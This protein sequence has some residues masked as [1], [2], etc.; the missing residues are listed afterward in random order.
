M[1]RII[2]LTALFGAFSILALGQDAK[3]AKPK[4][5]GTETATTTSSAA[6]LAKA[7]LAAHGG[8][9]LRSIKSLVLRGSVDITASASAQAIPATFAMIFSGEKY[10]LDLMNPFQPI[11]QVFDG[12]NTQTTVQN[13]F[14]LPPINRIGFIMLSKVG[15]PN[16]PVASLPAANKKK[17]GFRITSPE[18]FYTDYLVDE[19]TGQVKG[20]ESSYEVNGR[21]VTTSVAI[22][23]CRLVEGVLVPEKFS[24]RFDLG[25]LTAYADFKA[26]DI[27]V[28]TEIAN[29]VF[30]IQK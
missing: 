15:D 9:K 11:S 10:R 17:N 18:G 7:A 29:D 30:T 6:E 25:Q 8:E 13:G 19:K 28:N 4:E 5:E 26:K 1:R 3:T 22:D 14:E 27:Q 20:Y 23:K 16:F 24:Q 12:V 2:A 21:V